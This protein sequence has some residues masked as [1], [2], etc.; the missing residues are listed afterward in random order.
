MSALR[1]AFARRKAFIP[2]IMAGDPDLATTEALVRALS[3]AGAD[4]IELGVPFSDPIADGPVNQRAAERALRGGTTL[5]K[6]LELCRGLKSGGLTTPIVLFTYLNPLLAFGGPPEGA[7]ATLVLDPADDDEPAALAG[8]DRILL[9]SPTTTPARLAAV[10]ARA[11]SFVYYVSRLG[12]TGARAELPPGLADDVARVR[13][14]VERPLAVGFGVS[15]A[16]Q[17]AA[18]ARVADGVVV[19]SAIVQ[20]IEDLGR[21]AVGPVREFARELAQAVHD[22]HT[23]NR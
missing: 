22:T 7:D 4:A 9:A 13:A 16:E 10:R 18:V 20:R 5:A 6:V 21:D 12:V 2:F 19:G 14:A 23:T 1:D 17:A 11:G 8:R 3:D 15:T